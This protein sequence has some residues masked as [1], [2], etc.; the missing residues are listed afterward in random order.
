MGAFRVVVVGELSVIVGD[1]CEWLWDEFWLRVRRFVL[2]LA[3]GVV[4]L[5][6]LLDLADQLGLGAG[7]GVECGAV[8]VP[9][10]FG[11]VEAVGPA[12]AGVGCERFAG[13]VD[14]GRGCR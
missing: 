11:L 8:V 10:A 5:A 13:D 12:L 7:D 2:G 3:V 1:N 6:V 14:G 9:L 4:V